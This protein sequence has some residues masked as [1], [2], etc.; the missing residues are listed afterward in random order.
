MS[1]TGDD[2]DKAARTGLFITLL[3]GMFI[4]GCML[5]AGNAFGATFCPGDACRAVTFPSHFTFTYGGQVSHY[6]LT[7]SGQIARLGH[8]AWHVTAMACRLL[9]AAQTPIAS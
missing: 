5:W 2:F 6:M 4:L 3:L 9:P 8:G 1:V 7:C